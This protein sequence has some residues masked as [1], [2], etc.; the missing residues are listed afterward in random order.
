MLDAPRRVTS[1]YTEF[2]EDLLRPTKICVIWLLALLFIMEIW[3]SFEWRMVQDSP[4][5]HYVAFLISEHNYVP[6]RDVFETSMPGTFLYHL[7]LVQNLGYSDIAFRLADIGLLFIALALVRGIMR[8]IDPLAAWASVVT[9]GL[10]YLGLGPS[11]S[12]QRDF[13]GFVAV[14]SAIWIARRPQTSW[15]RGAFSVGALFGFAATVKPHLAIGAPA[16][17]VFYVNEW[18]WENL[19]DSMTWVKRAIR[20]FAI[21][22]VAFLLVIG[23]VLAW[24]WSKGALAAFWEMV[25][26][27][28]PLHVDMT[29]AIAT[30]TP[31]EK[32]E[33]V[34]RKL[35]RDLR[36]WL[37]PA[38]LGLFVAYFVAAVSRR[39]RRLVILLAALLVSYAIYPVL[40]AQFWIY[41]WLPFRIIAVMC[42]SL[43]LLQLKYFR[44]GTALQ[45]GF[46]GCFLVCALVWSGFMTLQPLQLSKPWGFRAQLSGLPAPA[47]KKGRV[48]EIAV[49]LQIA[50]LKPG[51]RVQPLDWTEG[52]VHAMLIAGA[53]PATPYIYD[54]HFYHYVSDPYIQEIRRRYISR[55]QAKPPRF[56]IDVDDQ[57]KPTGIDTTDT[58][59]ELD[60]FVVE[61]YDVAMAGKG[62]R[63][64]ELRGGR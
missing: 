40:A 31:A 26:R 45:Y 58:F 24:L 7:A 19:D 10:I 9:I 11:S 25:T 59:P 38:L 63:I 35:S 15:W 18:R 36:L 61:N 2:I 57:L 1:K 44:G 13:V 53:Q 29:G 22:G 37:P 64:L 12:L 8:Q 17:L 52:A 56:M 20:V 28:L 60:R 4:L 48:D 41:H 6:Y 46:G 50:D 14:L 33:Y 23:L 21:S 47:P 34:A 51:D 54:Y 49:F 27:Y 55:L 16:V 30:V 43:L 5:L 62:Y 32:A 39:Q 42:A 3:L